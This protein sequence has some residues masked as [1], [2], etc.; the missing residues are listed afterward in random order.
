M[1]PVAEAGKTWPQSTIILLYIIVLQLVLTGAELVLTTAY[2]Q[3]QVVILQH[4]SEEQLQQLVQYAYTGQLELAGPA[5][6]G[7]WVAAMSSLQ[8]VGLQQLQLEAGQL[9]D[10]AEDLSM[11][12]RTPAQQQQQQQQHQPQQQ[13]QHQQQ[14][15]P[16]Q[17]QQRQHNNIKTTANNK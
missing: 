9:Q 6:L 8:L 4:C 16:Q 12:P 10:R 11:K 17:Q 7:G 13:Q 3:D 2:V 1:S 14:Q 15:P 5:Q